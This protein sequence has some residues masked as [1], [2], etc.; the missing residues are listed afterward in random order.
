MLSSLPRRSEPG[1]CFFQRCT[2]C[3]Q[4]ITLIRL[5]CPRCGS[6]QI[7]WERSVGIGTV[8]AVTHVHR[9]PSEAFQ[10]L[11]PYT[12]VLVDLHE[13]PRVMAHGE[14]AL[15]IGDIVH[16]VVHPVAKDRTLFRRTDS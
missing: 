11:V 1:A 3:G 2:N 14:P 15:Q 6:T 8:F 16:A 7:G 4:A 12:L 13:G 5:A 9:A 10:P